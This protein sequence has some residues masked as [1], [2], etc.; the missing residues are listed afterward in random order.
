MLPGK[1]CIALLEEDNPVKAYFRVKPVLML[2]DGNYKVFEG[3]Q[4]LPMDGCLRI[5]PDKNESGRFKARMRRMGKYCLVDLRSYPIENDKIRNNKNYG[6]NTEERNAN[7]VYSDVVRE[8]TEGM[9]MEIVA[10]RSCVNAGTEQVL[11]NDGCEIYRR[12]QEA[13]GLG[14]YLEQDGTLVS[15]EE[16]VRVEVDGFGGSKLRLAIH[17]SGAYLPECLKPTAAPA[18]PATEEPVVKEAEI[19]AVST[20]IVVETP[21]EPKKEVVE[22][23]AEAAAER[24]NFSVHQRLSSQI[25][26]NPR[27]RMSLQEIIDEKWC[28]SREDQL[29]HPIPGGA[30]GQ[31]LES[32]V[33]R[34]VSAMREAWKNAD[35]RAQLIDTISD[36]GDFAADLDRRLNNDREN[37]MR[38][39]L[40]ELEAER[41]MALAQLDQLRKEKR[42]LRETFKAEIRVEEA[43]AFADAVEKTKAAEAQLA[44][45]NEQVEAVRADAEAVRDLLASLNDGRL[46]N[47]LRTFALKNRCMEVISRLTAG[48]AS[49]EMVPECAPDRDE[50]LDRVR[51]AFEKRG[52][53][54][55]NFECANALVIA[56]LADRVIVSGP[57]GSDRELMI[58]S[59]ADALG[60][61]AAK[62]VIRLQP[63]LCTVSRNIADR[64]N[65][66]SDVAGLVVIPQNGAAFGVV[67]GDRRDTALIG[68]CDAADTGMA[69][70]ASVLEDAWMIRLAPLPANT[71]WFVDSDNAAQLPS[72]SIASLYSA[73]LRN[74]PQLSE[75]LISRLNT[76]RA[77]L[78]EKGFRMSRKMLSDLGK[79]CA[80]MSVFSSASGEEI[81]DRGFAQRV[82]PC[83]LSS[84]GIGCL[85]ALRD[86][87]RGMPVS[88][89]L[90]NQPLP[91]DIIG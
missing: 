63:D 53:P 69:I 84:A 7:I 58:E 45:L 6:E 79:Y 37:A 34:A 70:P 2:E 81:L 33:A 61:I 72:A 21:V 35:T 85:N 39:A 49:P 19:E 59:L 55:G 74:L 27:G 64:L 43:R 14:E 10:D 54:A 75:N 13:S 78:A 9:I 16:I 46:E 31:P 25:G 4:I 51:A 68:I 44:Q 82:M 22:P 20:P 15:E 88:K 32:P 38:H 17:K 47:E 90:L 11:I 5:V 42:N 36:M 71:P 73:V 66:R 30:M 29:G 41:L 48:E 86:I 50:W 80:A 83:I 60:A 18:K 89:A 67:T 1:L 52:L 56:A 76:V 26:L 24:R 91:I 23:K 77:E 40:E 12:V 8:V 57:A 28:R 62:R 87:L 65:A 3:K